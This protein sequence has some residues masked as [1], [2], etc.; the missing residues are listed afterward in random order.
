MMPSSQNTEQL[1]L[2]FAVLS[3]NRKEPLTSEAEKAAIYCYAKQ[4]QSRGGGIIVKQLLEE[5][6]F[7]SEFVYAFWLFPWND[8]TLVLD[9]LKTESFH[10]KYRKSPELEDFIEKGQSSSR[11]IET[12][13]TF[14]NDNLN[15]FQIP[16]KET[17][18]VIE[19]LVTNEDF[20]DELAQSLSQTRQIT[21][22]FPDMAQLPF[23]IDKS[24]IATATDE[25]QKL[26]TT[27]QQSANQLYEIMK[28]LDATTQNF[29]KEIN[30]KI[31]DVKEEYSKKIDE[32]EVIAK[33][34]IRELE[35]EYGTQT[36]NLN[37]NFRREQ[38]PLQKER[39]KLENTL[40]QNKG[41]IERYK[42]EAKMSKA[43]K[44]QVAEKKWKQKLKIMA[45]ES[46]ELKTRMKALEADIKKV[47]DKKTLETFRLKS[48]LE[49]KIKEA[50]K[51]I[52]ELEAS[53]DVELASH[54][55]NAQNLS[56]LTSM[57]VE[58]IDKL[59]KMQGAGLRGLDKIGIQQSRDENT[60]I[61]IPFYLICYQSE[62]RRRYDL[63]LPS[64][65]NSV[66]FTVK[67]KGVL[68]KAKIKQLLTSRFKAVS[69]LISNLP[70]LMD[71]NPAFE[72]EIYEA[73]LA[74]NILKREKRE[75]IR[76]GLE[77]L[78]QEGWFTEK[79]YEELTQ[80]LK[81]G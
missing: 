37:K 46:N 39:T 25:L 45:K 76:S 68:G 9:G 30:M 69:P 72:R 1:I 27:F 4:N 38:L 62:T 17:E 73:G 75:Q 67:L 50:R 34:K 42:T 24:V 31:G 56:K 33:P 80:Q 74:T 35:D 44:D 78:K 19:A 51:D 6:A 64:V 49:T 22:S 7:A 52:A 12:Y 63:I 5:I 36:L 10:L 57:I 79:E 8:L 53:R 81:Q 18:K 65:I 14:L 3:E 47:E 41:K 26:K 59:A 60:L 11:T 55:Q 48:E 70:N 16:A 28:F 2:P 66:G 77:Q 15:F 32:Q 23:I 61:Y 20:L 54:E 58:Q 21:H 71:R 29:I 13:F 40:E 43:R